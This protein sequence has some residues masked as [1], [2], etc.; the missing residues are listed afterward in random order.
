M[1]LKAA[2][3]KHIKFL[4]KPIKKFEFYLEGNEEGLTGLNGKVA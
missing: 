1:T 4:V 3:W 2:T